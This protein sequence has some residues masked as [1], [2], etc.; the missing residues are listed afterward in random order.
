MVDL[1][2][3]LQAFGVKDKDMI[4]TLKCMGPVS[5]INI[6]GDTFHIYFKDPDYDLIELA[7]IPCKRLN[8]RGELLEILYSFKV[9]NGNESS[10]IRVRELITDSRYRLST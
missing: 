10:M 9:I 3:E 7:R 6:K 2:S 1:E 5:S 8:A 4:S